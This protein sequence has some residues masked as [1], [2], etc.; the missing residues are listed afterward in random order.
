MSALGRILLL[1]PKRITRRLQTASSMGVVDQVPNEW[2]LGLIVLRMWHRVLFRSD[3]VGTSPSGTVRNTRRARLF[4]NRA[5]RLPALL[6]TRAV[7]PMDYTGL[8]SSADRLIGHILKA[9]HDGIDF[10]Y[11]L[12]ILAC[13]PGGLETLVERTRSIV[14]GSN[15]KSEFYRDLV[16]YEGYHEGLLEVAEGALERGLELRP[17]DLDDPDRSFLAMIRWAA[18]EPDTPEAWFERALGLD[19]GGDSLPP[20]VQ[21]LLGAS[22]SDLAASFEAGAPI[23]PAD[24][25]DSD[26][27]GVSL[28]LPPLV[29]R[30]TWKKFAKCFRS[31]SDGV[32]GYNLRCEQNGLDAPWTPRMRDGHPVVFGPF[33]AIDDGPG[34]LLDYGK[35]S[36]GPVSR[37][38]DPL[39][40]L[41]G[42]PDL[43]LGRSLVQAGGQLLKTPSY[44]VLMRSQKPLTDSAN[45]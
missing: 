8:A 14:D 36:S 33:D 40:S 26:F 7:A 25:V 27:M 11:D 15:P 18:S 41:D 22:S 34:T 24:L 6:A 20:A 1:S 39:V 13:H 43:L 23:V 35:R 2:Q 16:V 9:H 45:L 42:S 4:Q 5:F 28:G 21:T 38:R 12:E 10:I 37:L 32:F 29:E 19:V 44:F 17:E 3:T 30:L 31:G